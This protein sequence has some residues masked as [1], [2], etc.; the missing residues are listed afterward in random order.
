MLILRKVSCVWTDNVLHIPFDADDKGKLGLLI[1]IETTA[2]SGQ[3]SESDL[4]TLRISVLL[5]VGLGTLE[6]GFALLLVVLY[7][8]C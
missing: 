4:F 5:D 2:L 8:V 7:T 3:S 6:D 1:N